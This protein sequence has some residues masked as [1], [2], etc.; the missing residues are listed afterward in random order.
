MP[1]SQVSEMSA[2]QKNVLEQSVLDQHRTQLST[3]Q[4]TEILPWETAGQYDFL[5]SLP[6]APAPPPF[7]SALKTRHKDRG[8]LAASQMA[9]A[10]MLQAIA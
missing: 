9:N 10:R 1:R 3:A 6:A 2:G 7:A 8:D 4:K 5:H